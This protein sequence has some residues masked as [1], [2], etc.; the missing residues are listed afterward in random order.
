[1]R[2]QMRCV[3]AGGGT[4]SESDLRASF[5]AWNFPEWYDGVRSRLPGHGPWTLEMLAEALRDERRPL[6]LGELLNGPPSVEQMDERARAVHAGTV[7]LPQIASTHAIAARHD[8]AVPTAAPSPYTP[9]QPYT[10]ALQKRRQQGGVA[11]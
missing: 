8:E 7:P 6:S 1:M 11:R 5:A 10:L 4:M 3:I 2:A 9:P